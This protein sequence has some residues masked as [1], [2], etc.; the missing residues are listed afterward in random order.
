MIKIA[1]SLDSVI[2]AVQ[3]IL[4]GRPIP[5]VAFEPTPEP[6]APGRSPPSAGIVDTITPRLEAAIAGLSARLDAFEKHHE[7]VAD[8]LRSAIAKTASIAAPGP[9]VEAPR[10]EINVAAHVV[11]AAPTGVTVEEVNDI[12]RMALER[13]QPASVAL[14]APDVLRHRVS[15]LER[16]VE[17]YDARLHQLEMEMTA[18]AMVATAASEG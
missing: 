17:K 9:A 12:L 7:L 3:A 11:H 18:L 6:E 16:S 1:H 13:V 2:E 14:P 15:N 4:D 10:R 8:D 5:A